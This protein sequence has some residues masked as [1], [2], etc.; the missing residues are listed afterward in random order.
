MLAGFSTL[1]AGIL[2]LPIII[3]TVGSGPYGVWIV[4]SVIATYLNYSDLGVGT[5]IVHFGSR[6]RGGDTSRSLSDYLSAGLLW[7]TLAVLIVMPIYFVVASPYSTGNAAKV[8]IDH[9]QAVSL[10][11]LG[12]IMT[13]TLLLKPFGSALTGAGLLPLDRRNQVWG[14]GLRVVGTLIAC[15]GFHNVV[16]VAAAEVAGALL[17]PLLSMIMTFT[18]RV[19]RLR[20]NRSSFGTLKFMLSYSARSFMMNATGALLLQAGTFIVAIVATPSSVTYFSAAFRI[21][22]SVRQLMGWVTDPFRPAL[23]RLFVNRKDEAVE[24]V[25]SILFSSLCTAGAGCLFLTLASDDVIRIWLGSSVPVA[26]VSTTVAILL[27]GLMLNAIHI[28]MIPS[29]DASGHPG[30]FFLIQCIWL[31]AFVGLGLWFGSMWGIVGV[32]LGLSLPLI[33]IEPLYLL[34]A[35]S[36][37]DLRLSKW[38]RTVAGPTL[39]IIGPGFAAAVGWMV[40]AALLGFSLLSVWTALA[41]L[42]GL[43]I[44]VAIFRHHLP[45]GRFRAALAVE[46]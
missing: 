15:F 33:V 31:G 36:V 5:A 13:L 45:F 11:V 2:L 34:K 8:G 12:A 14:A 38:A 10:V 19:A 27:I 26:E 17:P 42:I 30:A 6:T 32:A 7:N 23:S 29:G 39:M 28:P 21:Y 9:E 16:F 46:L 37:L 18:H 20:W 44:A 4:M 24:L 25:Y 40:I 1:L 35:R 43:V 3:S 22:S 41:F